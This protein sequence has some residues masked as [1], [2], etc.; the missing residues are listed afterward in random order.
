MISLNHDEIINLPS[1]ALLL[2]PLFG[3]YIQKISFFRRDL[4]RNVDSPSG[5]GETL[6]GIES[7]DILGRRKT[8]IFKGHWTWSTPCFQM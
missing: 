5:G 3:V 8:L 6:K 1:G 7:I 2:N 4:G